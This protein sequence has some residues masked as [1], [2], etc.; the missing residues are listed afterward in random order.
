MGTNE[1]N[2]AVRVRRPITIAMILSAA[3]H[4]A[5][6][7]LVSW[8]P[9]S[10]EPVLPRPLDVRVLT[11]DTADLGE[12]SVATPASEEPAANE[13]QSTSSTAR[14]IGERRAADSAELAD[15]PSAPR[16][17]TPVAEAPTAPEPVAPP[18]SVAEESAAPT[19]TPADEVPTPRVVNVTAPSP[20]ATQAFNEPER[21]MFDRQVRRWT[22]TYGD[23]IAPDAVTTWKDSGRQ[24]EARFAELPADD[25]TALDRVLVEVSTEIDGERLTT[26]LKMKRLAFSN[27]A[28]F[29]NRW[30]NNVQ[31]HDDELDGR[32]HSNSPINLAYSRT[33]KPQ[34]HGMVTTASRRIN[35]SSQRGRARRDEM[36]LGGLQTGVRSIRLPKHFVP[37]PEPA[38]IPAD[39]LHE[40]AEDTR[41]T[42]HEDGSYSWV[43]IDGGLFERRGRLHHKASYLLASPGA[44]L[45]VRGIVQGKV[46]VY[47]PDDIVI[48]GNLLYADHPEQTPSSRDYIGLVSMKTV[49]VADPSITGPG[50]LKV[51]A[52]IYAKRRFS[53]SKYRSRNNGLLE[54][55][56]SLTAGSLSATEPRFATRI[57][58]DPRL[59]EARP[60]GFP[61][62]DRYEVE[63]WDAAWAVQSA[64]AM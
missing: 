25:D 3:L 29:V 20:R 6:I 45:H 24:Y 51:H 61:V 8:R 13:E 39:Q 64:E 63:S 41:I 28:Q 57:R 23:R 1:I 15:T 17:P 37:L 50:D 19:T 36:F 2:A 5:V 62:T 12:H 9:T 59:E 33:T 16:S 10:D 54:I 14:E 30:D 58:F 53:V 38:A 21:K 49:K 40:F 31:I 18:A 27:Y 7:F 52:A 22:E 48:A 56:G 44:A 34:F 43:A 47:S 35:I 4:A 60:P 32:F 11:A 26:T 42:F 46:L 55:Y